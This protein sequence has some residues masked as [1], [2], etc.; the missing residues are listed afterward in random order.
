MKYAL[1]TSTI[2]L[3]LATGCAAEESDLEETPVQ[4]DS[5]ALLGF[6]GTSVIFDA[7]ANGGP[8]S[9]NGCNVWY[10]WESFTPDA[11]QSKA[12]G[13]ATL[14]GDLMSC[15][16]AC[17]QWARPYTKGEAFNYWFNL[18]HLYIYPDSLDPTTGR[19]T[20]YKNNAAG[21]NRV[22]RYE[23]HVRDAN[24]NWNGQ[25]ATCWAPPYELPREKGKLYLDPV[26]SESAICHL[27]S[28][29]L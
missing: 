2:L 23:C 27:E 10:A 19:Y 3:A 11:T 5:A 20:M 22:D 8:A 12:I 25:D 6:S 4:S 26:E 29:Q 7:A 21:S 14:S 1:V 18:R 13:R 17:Q 28:T 24:W 9:M 16:R 15:A